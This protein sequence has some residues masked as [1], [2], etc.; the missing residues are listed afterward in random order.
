MRKH[1][2]AVRLQ[3][4]LILGIASLCTALYLDCTQRV[5]VSSSCV[6]WQKRRSV[7]SDENRKIRWFFQVITARTGSDSAY[8]SFRWIIGPWPSVSVCN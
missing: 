2:I 5:S 1:Y 3:G 8:L 4:R 6:V 7:R